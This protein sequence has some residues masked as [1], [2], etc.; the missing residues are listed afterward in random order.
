EI[1][2]RS[3]FRNGRGRAEITVEFARGTDMDFARLELSERLIALDDE[4]PEGSRT[5]V[6]EQYIPQEFRDQEQE[7][8]SY[9]VTGPLTLEALRAHV[10]DV[11]APEILQVEG[12]ANVTARGGRRRALQVELDQNQLRALGLNINQV[13]LQIQA[14]EFVGEVGQIAT[15]GAL[16]TLAVR[17]TVGSAEAVRNMIVSGVGRLVRL[18]DIATIRDTYEEPT[19]Y[20][21]IDGLPAVSFVVEK[22][23]GTNV[24]AVADRV[25]ARLAAIT[26]LHPAG[27]RL[28][29]DADESEEVR[30]QLTDLRTRAVI[31]AGVVFVVLLMFLR[32]F[33]S[34]GIVFATI[35][36]S[37]LIALN[38]IYF[39]GYT[40]NVLTL[41]GLAMGF[42]LIVDNAIVVLENIYRRCNAGEGALEA[43]E[44]GAREVLLPILAATLTTLIVFI[45][46]VYLQGELRIFYIP[47][48]IV[49]G[50][51]LMGSLFVA[52]SFIPALAARV[53]GIGYGRGLDL[54]GE[55]RDPFYVRFYSELVRFTTR[56]PWVTVVLALG[57]FGGSYHLFDKYVQRGMLW[58]GFGTSTFISIRFTQ[59]SG[60]ELARTDELV[61]YF[62]ERL[63]EI[64]E[65]ERFSSQVQAQFAGIRVDFPD[66][67]ENTDIPPA[68]KE[69]LLA[70][71]YL[72]GGAEVRVYGYGPSF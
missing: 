2:S 43:S 64:P 15:G 63:A 13:R 33:R 16:R 30:N 45:P 35:G 6:V 9:T 10:D 55:R 14:L 20:Y 23:L 62:E 72:F 21:R 17:Q 32:S 52:F 69:Q 68:V 48:A 8:L 65:V 25:K 57:S 70:Y 60:A 7:F 42:G 38:L 41:M 3:S 66:E 58:G 59:P 37:I 46:F 18:S 71:S 28:I 44:A 4:L 39:S 29:L 27:V 19:G 5:P 1:S 50:M 12:V 49:V 11:I 53:L 40:L 26:H 22:E 36:F 56:H 67:L 61:R 47:L 54:R 24:V 51:S 34:A 31:A